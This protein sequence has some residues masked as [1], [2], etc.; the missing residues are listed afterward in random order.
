MEILML[1]RGAAATFALVLLSSCAG[2]AAPSPASS[3][4]SLRSELLRRVTQDQAIRDT[5]MGS[6]RNAAG[7]PDSAIARRMRAVDADNTAWLMR[8]A[9]P[10][11]WFTTKRVG[12]DGMEAAFL[13][14]QHSDSSVQNQLLP[15]IER[16]FVAGEIS[17]QE[18]AL[19]S[20]RVATSFGRPQAYG[21]Q[22]DIKDGRVLF[23]PIEDS[24]GVDGRRAK[25]GMMPLREYA[26]FLDSLYVRRTS[27]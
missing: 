13:L 23:H 7:I 8:V 24:I 2:D 14:L 10:G 9:G 5:V 25:K 17:G 4:A 21:T 20:D 22:A 3:D 26:A 16:S 18:F 12:R 6:M 15:T 11:N 1:I 27:R 19:L